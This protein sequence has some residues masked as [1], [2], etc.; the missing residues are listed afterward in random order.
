MITFS[1]F[2]AETTIDWHAQ[3]EEIDS[4]IFQNANAYN[5]NNKLCLEDTY[6]DRNLT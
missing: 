2:Y 4:R 6:Q 1:D 3:G 5:H